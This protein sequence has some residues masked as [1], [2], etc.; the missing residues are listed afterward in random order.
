MV[1]S[2]DAEEAPP[3]RSFTSVPVLGFVPK[4]CD[5]SDGDDNIILE[6]DLL[7][8]LEYLCLDSPLRDKHICLLSVSNVGHFPAFPVS[9]VDTLLRTTGCRNNLCGG[10]PVGKCADT[11]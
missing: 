9:S 2:G 1:S 6:G 10:S 7:T 4:D 8:K 3:P 5:N 11:A